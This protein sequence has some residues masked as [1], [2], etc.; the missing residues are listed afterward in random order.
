MITTTSIRPM[1]AAQLPDF[2]VRRSGGSG[3]LR[4]GNLTQILRYV[5]DN[6]ASSRHDIARGCG[7]GISTMTDLIGELR[8]RRLLRELDPIRR[9]GAGRPTR[10]I[11]FD[12]EPW[13]VLGVHV[14]L[15]KVLF[16]ASTVGGRE[17]W[18]DTVPADLRDSGPE[19]YAQLDELLRAQLERI[20]ADQQ[21]IAIEVGL[22][23]AIAAD[24]TTVLD[25]TTFG[26]RDFDLGAA[27]RGTLHAVGIEHASVSVSNE[28]QLAALVAARVELPLPADAI[29]VYFGGTR[30][31]GGGLITRGEIFRGA[32]GGAGQFGHLNV[33]PG[34]PSCWCGRS[35]CLES[36]AGP[37]A[38]LTN[39]GLVPAEEARA[40]V[41]RGPEAALATLFEAA[42]AGEPQ[43]LEAL[44]QAGDVLGRAIDDLIGP[45]NPHAVI[46]GGYLGVVSEHVLPRL[47][48]RLA[49]R[50]ASPAYAGTELMAL[51]GLRPRTL[52]G[53]LMAARDACLYDPL[54]LT[55]PVL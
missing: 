31:I 54:A 13:C 27:V 17:L 36:L 26:W 4:H 12:G 42:G 20:P 28:C 34:G 29:A 30:T 44:A 7:L 53:A 11:D 24:R 50:L 14:N 2:G 38:V 10:P 6:G 47:R 55:R 41:D 48:E 35:G 1:P 51:A 18:S 52:Q 43:V 15:D 5:R 22:G 49:H 25:N 9:P 23:G 21:L 45:V 33:D 16:A 40:V 37:A 3:D 32:G 8:S 19:G 46:L 39:A